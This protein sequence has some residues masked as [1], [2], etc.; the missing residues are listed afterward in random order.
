MSPPP[1]A[2]QIEEGLSGDREVCHSVP[3][4]PVFAIKKEKQQK[5]QKEIT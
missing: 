4:S 5:Q 3:P 2:N 1:W